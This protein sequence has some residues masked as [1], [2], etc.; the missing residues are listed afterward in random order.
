MRNKYFGLVLVFLFSLGASAQQITVT[1]NNHTVQQLIQDVL[2]DGACAQTSNWTSSTGTPT[3]NGIGYY[4]KNGANF[5]FEKGIILSSGKA[6]SAPGPNATLLSDGTAAWAGDTQLNALVAT[7]NANDVT[8][9]ASVIEFDFVPPTNTIKF[10]Y[11]LASEEY[12]GTFP[13]EFSDVF[14]FILSGPGINNTNAYNHD[15]NPATPDINVDMGG[16]NIALIPGT[17]IPASITNIHNVTGCS[18]GNLGSVA[19]PA[20]YDTTLSGNGA[21]NFNGQTIPLTAEATVVPGQTYHIKLVIADFRDQAY[22]SAVFLEGGSF[23]LGIDLNVTGLSI[24]NGAANACV[25]ETVT[26]NGTVNVAN[27][28]YQWYKDNVLIPGATNPTLAVTQQG[29]YKLKASIPI[30]G[31]TTPCEDEKTITVNFHDIPTANAAQDLRMC[32]NG[33]DGVEGFTLTANDAAVLGSQNAANFTVSYHASQTDAENDQNPLTSPYNNTSNNQVIYARIDNNGNTNCKAITSFKLTLDTVPTATQP[34]NPHV[35][36]CDTGNNNSE[37]FNLT[38]FQAGILGSQSLTNFDITYHTSQNDADND[39]NPIAT[40]NAYI[41]T[42]ATQVI[43]VRVD[44]KVNNNC[45]ATTSFTLHIDTIP[46]AGNPVD[47]RLCDTDNDVKEVFDLTQNNAA[48]L[49]GQ[50]AADFDISYHLSPADAAAGTNAI[51]NPAA[52]QSTTLSD[53]IYVRIQNKNNTSC[54]DTSKQFT[55]YIDTIY[56]AATAPQNIVQCDDLSNNGV[57]NFNL[58]Q[59]TPIIM[60]GL[61]TTLATLTYHTSAA[62]ATADTNAIPAANLAAYSSGS[63][64]IHYRLENNNNP[65]CFTTGSFQLV[66]NPRPTFANTNTTFELCFDY[67]ANGFAPFDLN[68][69]NNSFTGGTAN[70]G[71][72]YHLNAND[73]ENDVNPLP[74]PYT[75]VANPQI[76]HVRLED[77]TTGC[78]RVTTMTL[79]VLPA[80]NA[81]TPPPV[82]VC[83]PDND[84]IAEFDLS[85][86]H[87]V[88]TGNIPTGI[89]HYYETL[90]QA[91][92][93]DPNIT[94]PGTTPPVLGTINPAVPYQNVVENNQTI[95]ARVALAPPP[96]TCYTIVPIQ[97]QVIKSPILPNQEPYVVKVCDY[98]GDTSDDTLVYNLNSLLPEMLANIT[99]TAAD[100]TVSFYTSNA[101]AQAPQNPIINVTGHT[102]APTG[103]PPAVPA[104]WIR[105][106]HNTT[107]CVSIKKINFEVNNPPVITHD[108]YELC[109]DKYWENMDEF[110]VFDLDSRKDIITTDASVTGITFHLTDAD[111]QAGSNPIT[112]TSAFT[113]TV[114]P[115]TIH[116]RVEGTEG[117]FSVAQL[118]LKVNPNPTP[119]KPAQIAATLGDI[120]SCTNDPAHTNPAPGGTLQQ[121]YAQ[122]DLNAYETTIHSGEPDVDVSYFTDINDAR[123]NVNAIPAA[124]E[125]VF[126]NTVPFEQTIYVRVEK[127]GTKCYTIT[128]F[129]IKVPTPEVKIEGN[130]VLCVDENGVPLPDNPPLVLTAKPG[131]DAANLYTYQWALN[132]TNIPGATQQNYTVIQPGEYTVT[133]T[134]IGDTECKNFTQET[135][136]VSAGPATFNANVTTNAFANP[137]QIVVNATS[138][139]TPAVTFEYS[140]DDSNYTTNNTF[141]NVKP[142]YNDVYIRDKDGC[143]KE[144]VR[145]LVVHYPQFFTPNGDGVNDTWNIIGIGNIPISQIYI[146]DRFGKL[147]KQIDPDSN[148][149]DGMYNGHAMPASDYWFKI[150]YLEGTTNP[151]QKEFRAH[152]TLKR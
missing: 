16:K 61:S 102:L 10:Q 7:G 120:T 103:T 142:G 11:L 21:T 143:A 44:N 125:D 9:N 78:Y 96:S 87:T 146:F 116:V 50:A 75:N 124:H 35:R 58:T 133:I 54:A 52:H 99:G 27:V 101:D 37:T 38:Q 67:T 60:G 73:A 114:N 85:N 8:H 127:Q 80:L 131:P 3:N 83:D 49:N 147:L 47:L 95:Y 105:V 100:Y 108:T 152:F 5:P 88:L 62:N 140:L 25:G 63:A 66:L 32:D 82:K 148:G 90:A 30:P 65:T 53:I 94:V 18:A 69:Q 113:N 51:A 92:A 64:T 28:V 144:K 138:N 135:V 42:T 89:V 91:Q 24:V 126:Y 31:S 122:F 68:T 13:C 150:I 106:E 1:D 70:L 56:S 29:D 23:A 110:N 33:A 43:Y 17:N 145:V 6:T 112:N 34:G 79:R 2:V 84:G 22:D 107:R 136:T 119:L 141:D 137:A 4:E 12:T 139:L 57:E 121:G 93:N 26:I 111:A 81:V 123:L 104:V 40:P 55:I 151:V 46:V 134:S 128:S 98:D 20:F 129:K 19:L 39:Q 97:L 71:V 48:I 118:N 15:A 36:L 130:K 59:Q 77:A 86:L 72:T 115:Q 149:W 132:G 14:A 74:I 76:I 109:D 45:F 41:S 117:C